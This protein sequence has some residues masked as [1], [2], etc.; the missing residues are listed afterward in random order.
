MDEHQDSWFTKRQHCRHQLDLQSQCE[1]ALVH[2]L[3]QHV[4]NTTLATLRHT[5][6]AIPRQQY[7]QIQQ[8]PS[9][10]KQECALKLLM[11]RALKVQNKNRTL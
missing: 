8:P 9:N 3:Q 5:T 7:Y 10:T 11:N 4:S 2:K 1:P 6:S